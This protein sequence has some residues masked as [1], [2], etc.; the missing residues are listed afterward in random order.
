MGFGFSAFPR[1]DVEPH[2]STRYDFNN[3][4][5]YLTCDWSPFED[6][7]TSLTIFAQYYKDGELFTENT[8]SRNV[9]TDETLL[10]SNLGVTYG[11]EVLFVFGSQFV[12]VS[13]FV[14]IVVDLKQKLGN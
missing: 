5:F 12:S 14:R 1:I 2:L 4:A 7:D 3:S 6:L 13:E 10:S 11:S 8:I 9:T